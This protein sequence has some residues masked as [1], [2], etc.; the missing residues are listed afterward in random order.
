MFFFAVDYT[1]YSLDVS[2]HGRT[3]HA[4]VFWF[5]PSQ[6]RSDSLLQKWLLLCAPENFRALTG[7][8][9]YRGRVSRLTGWGWW[10]ACVSNGY[11]TSK[12]QPNSSS[13]YPINLELATPFFI[14]ISKFESK[15]YLYSIFVQRSH[16]S[17]QSS[18][19]RCKNNKKY[20]IYKVVRRKI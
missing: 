20:K 15:L 16:S 4:S 9:V 8:M 13:D 1:G 3:A 19:K 12:L 18:R 7:G 14:L 10:L 17:S 6:H 5:K 11:R 2:N